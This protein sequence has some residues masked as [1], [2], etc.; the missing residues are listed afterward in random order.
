M[1]SGLDFTRDE[2][3]LIANQDFFLAKARVMKKIRR[4]LEE[5]HVALRTELV[6]QPLLSPPG[7]DPEKCQF[8][9]GEHLEDCPYQYLDFPKHFAGTEK[10][11]F[12]SLF[13]WGHH[14]VFALILEGEG[15]SRYKQN[16]LNRF[17]A[18]AGRNLA[19]CLS[20]SLWEWKRGEGYALPMTP[21]RRTD[22]AA[23]LSSRGSFK[24]ARFVAPGDP[25]IEQ[26]RLVEVGRDALRSMLPIITV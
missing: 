6:G 4:V 11:T 14:F 10:F 18:V 12:R 3:A 1:A 19:L 21:E 17:P 5:L 15:L 23:A 16:L 13:W 25:A 24:I 9:K 26:G 7:F 2:I 20:P 8:V 22:V